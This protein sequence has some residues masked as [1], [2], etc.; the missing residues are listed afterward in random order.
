MQKRRR[1]KPPLQKALQERLNLLTES[2]SEAEVGQKGIELIKE[3]KE[4]CS[5]L[6]ENSSTPKAAAATQ[7]LVRWDMEP[8]ISATT[9]V[10]KSEE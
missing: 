6:E 1:A 7:V 3:M 9:A 5:M 2:L 4:L 8:P 10:G